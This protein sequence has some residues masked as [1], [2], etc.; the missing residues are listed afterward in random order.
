[1][2][3]V[4]ADALRTLPDAAMPKDSKPTIGRFRSG[5]NAEKIAHHNIVDGLVIL[6]V[7]QDQHER[8]DSGERQKR[9]PEIYGQA[10]KAADQERYH[11][12][13]ELEA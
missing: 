13:I 4:V 6:I 2:S 3:I 5:E 1:M 10:Q 7:S 11:V 9:P 12:V 8:D